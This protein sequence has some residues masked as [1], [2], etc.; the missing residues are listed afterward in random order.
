MIKMIEMDMLCNEMTK[1]EMKCEMDMLCNEMM[2][3]NMEYDEYNELRLSVE[4]MYI[5]DEL[6]EDECRSI[7]VSV[8]ERYRRYIRNINVWEIKNRS[9]MYI[10]ENIIKFLSECVVSRKLELMEM[11]DKELMS[12]L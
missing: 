10:R 6:S 12:V 1:C 5:C 11:I 8:E 4:M 3:V 7:L 2:S 9:Y